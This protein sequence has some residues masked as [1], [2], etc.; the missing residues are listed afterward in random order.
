MCEE[1]WL[2]E[3]I[4]KLRIQMELAEVHF[5]LD[6]LIL[7]RTPEVP[8]EITTS[9]LHSE[10]LYNCLHFEVICALRNFFAKF[11]KDNLNL[12]ATS[13]DTCIVHRLLGVKTTHNDLS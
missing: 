7:N 5:H 10:V 4:Y 3:E 8:A 6:N 11:C 1:R 9:G 12:L 13:Y 2:S